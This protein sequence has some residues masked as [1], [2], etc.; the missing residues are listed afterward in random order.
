MTT[1]S[2]SI[3]TV[4]ERPVVIKR[5]SRLREARWE[6]ILDAAAS[7]FNE[8]GY[9]AA[10]LQDIADRVGILKGSLYYYIKTKGDLL[11]SLLLQV[12]TR[13]LD[14]VRDCLGGPGD[15]IERLDRLIRAYL[16][17]ILDNPERTR[18]YIHEVRQLCPRAKE[19]IFLDRSI[20]SGVEATVAEGQAAGLIRTDLDPHVA[21]QAMLGSLNAIYQWEGISD[22]KSR[23]A[24]IE[25]MAVTM[26][27]GLA[28]DEGL[29]RLR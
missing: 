5:P 14:L 26:L 20:R 22:R 15:I 25:H 23:E 2:D 11:E 3:S 28:S 19:K 29:R 1:G 17:F 7:V 13:G 9:S 21:A 18:V 16:A 4:A 12:H 6:Q 24:V 8:K 10:S 27:R